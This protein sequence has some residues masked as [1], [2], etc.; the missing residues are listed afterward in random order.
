VNR[1]VAHDRVAAFVERG[2]DR[3]RGYQHAPS[4]EG[5][6]GHPALDAAPEDHVRAKIQLA[7]PGRMAID[8]EDL[9][10]LLGTVPSFGE[11]PAF[12]PGE[13]AR[14]MWLPLR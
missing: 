13:K 12:A 9:A 8:D 11:D 6:P 4:D 14:S 3:R 1:P 10:E 7:R 2:G 5:E